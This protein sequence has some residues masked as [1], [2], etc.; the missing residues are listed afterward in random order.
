MASQDNH[1]Q[2]DA[3]EF[4]AKTEVDNA[5]F[6]SKVREPEG[7]CVLIEDYRTSRFE[8]HV[9]RPRDMVIYV[10]KRIN[11]RMHEIAVAFVG[12]VEQAALHSPEKIKRYQW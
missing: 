3:G 11:S 9:Y 2:K 5:T 1:I 8:L 10:S 7:F 12:N 6:I 4:I